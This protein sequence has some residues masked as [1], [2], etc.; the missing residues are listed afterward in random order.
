[1]DAHG[2][3]HDYL[4][5]SLTDR[6]NFRCQY[7]MPAE[8]V[9]ILER[10]EL[11]TFEE[12]ERLVKVF[13]RLGVSKVRLTGGEPTVRRGFMELTRALGQIE[14]IERLYLTTNGSALAPKAA[15]LKEAGLTGVNISLDTLRAERFEE[16]T[17]R[18]SFAAVMAGIEAA[19]EAGLST[20]IN[21]VVLPG[22]NDDEL[23]DFVEF[24]R[25]RKVQVR[26]IEFMPF[27]GNLWK[28]DRVYDYAAMQRALSSKF[29][30]KPLAGVHG[31]VAKE[32]WI[33]GFV[34]TV[35]FITSMTDSFCSTCNRVRLTSDGRFKTCLFLPPRTS[36]RDMV[37]AGAEDEALADAIRQDLQTKWEAHPPMNQWKQLESL[38]MVQIGG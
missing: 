1:M 14:G 29:D 33:E 7:C 35:G 34:G 32:F 2:R 10:S 25:G 12:I 18:D 37:R 28:P 21:V 17:R 5:V 4:R 8:G 26:F 27:A 38:S 6:C 11:L 16:I 31:D 13:A 15:E 3:R 30:L 24:V 19:L 9:D 36:L 23:P 22:L 20:K